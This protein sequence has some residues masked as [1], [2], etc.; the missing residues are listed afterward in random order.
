MISV[1]EVVRQ[2]IVD[3]DTDKRKGV[4]IRAFQSKF[5]FMQSN[6]TV[7]IVNFDE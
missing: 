2:D 7:S 1:S 5:V 4:N 6:K 3:E